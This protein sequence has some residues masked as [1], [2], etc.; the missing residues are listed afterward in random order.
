MSSG[1]LAFLAPASVSSPRPFARPAAQFRTIR[2]TRTT[3][4]LQQRQQAQ[5]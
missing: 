5:Q 1:P 4:Q 3:C 2:T